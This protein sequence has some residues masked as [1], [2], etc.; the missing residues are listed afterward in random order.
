[1][2]FA[3][4]ARSFDAIEFG[5]RQIH[6]DQIGMRAIGLQH[7]FFA[8]L[9]LKDFVPLAAEPRGEQHAIIDVVVHYKDRRRAFSHPDIP[10]IDSTFEI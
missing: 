9:G 1:V 4:L 5:H 3:K 8:V 2:A 10:P 6:Q 7:A